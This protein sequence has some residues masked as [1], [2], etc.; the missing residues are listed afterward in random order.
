VHN[1]DYDP[2]KTVGGGGLKTSSS[3]TMDAMESRERARERKEM[4]TSQESRWH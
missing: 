1:V 4:F 3:G 2:V